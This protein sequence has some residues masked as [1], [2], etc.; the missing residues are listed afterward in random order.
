L[1]AARELIKRYDKDKDDVVSRE[2]LGFTK[3]LFAS[4]DRNDDGNLSALEL[5]RWLSA[6]PAG[7]FTVQL[8]GQAQP[9]RDRLPAAKVMDEMS[10]N[11]EG[12]RINIIQQPT[13]L[14]VNN[15]RYFLQVFT[16][17]AENKGFVTRKQ[18]DGNRGAALQLQTMFD[19]GDRD[20]DG[21]LTEK[22]LKAVLTTMTTMRGAQ[23]SMSIYSTGNGMFQVLDANSDGQLSPREMRSAWK[24]LGAMD[25]DKDGYITRSEFPQQFHLSVAQGSSGGFGRV[26]GAPGMGSMARPAGPLRGPLWFRKM[27]RNGD[28]DISRTEWLGTREDFDDADADRDDML[29]AD[30][31]EA[32]DA[33]KRKAEE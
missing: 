25:R 28:G 22:E 21:K 15:E 32:Y 5:A 8:S 30:E 31:A 9:V 18:L 24:R 1:I 29:S 13:F 23:V 26:V 33:K 2:E 14:N 7:E 19:L 11:L 27:D 17:F 12:V 6:K 20:N 4:L 3:E 10:V 16:E